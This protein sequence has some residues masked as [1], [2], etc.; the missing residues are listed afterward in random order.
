MQTDYTVS[1]PA[2]PTLL[3]AEEDFLIIAGSIHVTYNAFNET[4]HSRRREDRREKRLKNDKSEK[5]NK[6]IFK[7]T[8]AGK[9]GQIGNGETKYQHSHVFK[10]A[11]KPENLLT[12]M[13]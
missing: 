1:L 6:G 12:Q 7:E 2:F 9:T 5:G 4:T 13:K 8:S 11:R 3:S 10:P